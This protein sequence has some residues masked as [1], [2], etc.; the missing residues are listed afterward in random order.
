MSFE[1]QGC[2]F[3]HDGPRFCRARVLK[4]VK[5]NVVIIGLGNAGSWEDE[6]SVDAADVPSAAVG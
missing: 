6:G 4:N 3:A 1:I 5:P 2:D